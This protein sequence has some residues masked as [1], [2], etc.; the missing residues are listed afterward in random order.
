[1]AHL[2]QSV[3]LLFRFYNAVHHD[4]VIFFESG[5]LSAA[6]RLSVLSLCAGSRARFVTLGAEHFTVPAGAPPA[7]RWEQLTKF[8]VGYRHMMF[9]PPCW[10]KAR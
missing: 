9:A 1:M 5:N 3:R 7:A 2:R 6:D 4:D 10:A 8:S